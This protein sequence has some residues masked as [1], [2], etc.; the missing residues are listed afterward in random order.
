MGRFAVDVNVGIASAAV[1]ATGA[2]AGA[3]LHQP[4]VMVDHT[5]CRPTWLAG[6]W[7]TSVKVASRSGS[8][9]SLSSRIFT[10]PSILAIPRM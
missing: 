9:L 8:P 3:P 6:Y 5:H 4:I 1:T 2:Q 10:P 7:P